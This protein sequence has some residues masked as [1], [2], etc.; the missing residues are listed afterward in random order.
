MII[1][2]LNELADKR[3]NALCRLFASRK[4]E[5]IKSA[6]RLL[7]EGIFALPESVGLFIIKI[8]DIL[9]RKGGDMMELTPEDREV[10]SRVFKNIV[11][12]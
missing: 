2:S 4:K 8:A 12:P 5:K 1:L 9:F 3:H 7:Q 6:V 11:L 10:F